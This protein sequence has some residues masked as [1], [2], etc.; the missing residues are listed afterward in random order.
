[1]SRGIRKGGGRSRLPKPRPEPEAGRDDWD[2]DVMTL[3]EAVEYL[4]CHYVT[5]FKLANRGEIPAFRVGG[6]RVGG[7]WRCR[8]SD[9]NRWIADRQVKPEGWGGREGKG[10]GR[11]PKSGGE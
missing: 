6:H 1:M 4:N 11:W 3:R 7:H 8:W 9:I 5:V 2:R 10:R